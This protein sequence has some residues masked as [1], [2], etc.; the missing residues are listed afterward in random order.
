MSADTL[1]IH[2]T[3]EEVTESIGKRL[4]PLL[5]PGA[6]VALNGELASGKTCLVRGLVSHFSN[7]CPVSSPTFTIVNQY[8]GPPTIFHVDLYRTTTAAEILD[9]GYEEL[10]DSRDGLCIVEWADRAEAL[11]PDKRLDIHLEHAGGDRRTITFRNHDLLSS[12][13]QSAI[14]P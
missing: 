3:S 2:S 4:A 12:D 5:Q 10:F 8:D 1:V 14:S 13:W 6:F 9:L 7:D 11:L